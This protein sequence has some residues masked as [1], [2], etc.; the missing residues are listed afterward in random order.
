MR[1]KLR[2]T[3]LLVMIMAL[4]AC[5]KQEP[6]PLPLVVDPHPQIRVVFGNEC[7]RSCLDIANATVDTSSD[8][9]RCIVRVVNLS[10]Q[11]VPLEYKV[12]WEDR[13]GAPLLFTSA[14]Q[15]TPVAESGEKTIVNM[16]KTPGAVRATVTLRFPE[17]VQIWVPEPDPATMQMQAQ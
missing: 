4:C 9:P 14:W 5:A 7:V 10:Q 6:Q 17:D 12:V 8:L 11:K 16:A 13:Y 1:M 15:R 2:L 3:V